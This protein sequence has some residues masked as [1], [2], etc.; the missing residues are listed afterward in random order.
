[1]HVRQ[2]IV[3]SRLLATVVHLVEEVQGQ[4]RA[5]RLLASNLS[6]RSGLS[7]RHHLA[8]PFSIAAPAGSSERLPCA[9]VSW[10][11][12]DFAAVEPGFR[13]EA[14]DD[15]HVQIH[16]G[17]LPSNASGGRA[18]NALMQALKTS[19]IDP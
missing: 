12:R 5:I 15:G 17:W 7:S 18:R 13:E 11:Q 1:V 2:E 9:T 8:Y 16:R 3:R 19:F 10:T 6:S 4:R 14:V